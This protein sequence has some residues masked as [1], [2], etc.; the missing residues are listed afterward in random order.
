MSVGGAVIGLQRKEKLVIPE[1]A[2]REELINAF[3]HWNNDS[4]SGSVS[5]VI[6]DEIVEIENLGHLPSALTPKTMKLPHDSY[7]AN[8]DIADV[9]FKI[10]F[11]DSLGSG[12]KRMVDACNE[13][14]L[15]KP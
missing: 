13:A 9:L 12:V 2:M 8:V 10:K 11:L 6:Y 7:P 5:M 14:G 3:C 15:P 1:E 4:A